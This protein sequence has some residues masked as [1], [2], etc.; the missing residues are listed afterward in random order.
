MK[1]IRTDYDNSPYQ[2]DDWVEKFGYFNPRSHKE[3]ENFQRIIAECTD[4]YYAKDYSGLSREDDPDRYDFYKSQ[5]PTLVSVLKLMDLLM[6]QGK[7]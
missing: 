5:V 2:L 7:L 4:A 6:A 3:M 1:Q